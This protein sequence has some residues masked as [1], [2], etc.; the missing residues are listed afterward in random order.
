MKW[1]EQWQQNNRERFPKTAKFFD[2]FSEVNQE[3]RAD[4][5]N[6]AI[7]G[8]SFAAAENILLRESLRRYPFAM[9]FSGMLAG[10]YAAGKHAYSGLSELAKP[11]TQIYDYSLLAYTQP[12]DE[13]EDIFYHSVA[14]A[15]KNNPNLNEI[16]HSATQLAQNVIAAI[17]NK[18]SFSKQTI[19]ALENA[20]TTLPAKSFIAS[21]NQE[22]DQK[23]ILDP[24]ERERYVKAAN[25]Y[26]ENQLS[27]PSCNN[28]E[29]SKKQKERLELVAKA[30]GNALGLKDVLDN[31]HV[32][33]HMRPGTIS[34]REHNQTPAFDLNFLNSM[35]AISVLG[36]A[37]NNPTLQKIGVVGQA[38]YQIMSE[39]KKVGGLIANGSFSVGTL[40]NSIS[41]I[42]MAGSIVM[43][44]FGRK[45]NDNFT[46]VIMK[47]LKELSQQMVNFRNEV[48]QGLAEIYH[49]QK[50]IYDA[51]YNG[52]NLI[53]YSL[54]S[55][56]ANLKYLVISRL[57]DIQGH[58]KYLEEL[59]DGNFQQLTRGP[60]LRTISLIEGEHDRYIKDNTVKISPE[61]FTEAMNEL[62]FW[63]VDRINISAHCRNSHLTGVAALPKKDMRLQLNDYIR[64]IK[65]L[66]G[67]ASLGQA[68]GFLLPYAQCYLLNDKKQIELLDAFKNP[69]NM[70]IWIFTVDAYKKL[71]VLGAHAKIAYDTDNSELQ[72]ILDNAN[73]MLD[74]FKTI[75]QVGASL[76]TTLAEQY[77]QVIDRL[78][79]QLKEQAALKVERMLKEF[80]PSRPLSLPGVNINVQGASFNF[81]ANVAIA[82]DLFLALQLDLAKITF[83]GAMP[84]RIA[85][86]HPFAPS[87]NAFGPF[88]GIQ[89]K[90]DAYFETKSIPNKKI[91]LATANKTI[92]L[93]LH[94]VN[95]ERNK[96]QAE[97]F[98]RVGI[99]GPDN[100]YAA[101][102]VFFQ[103]MWTKD[104][105][106]SFT[107]IVTP[108]N[109]PTI[110]T[111]LE[112]CILKTELMALLATDSVQECFTQLNFLHTLAHAYAQL[113]GNEKFFLQLSS[114]KPAD[115]LQIILASEIASLLPDA[116]MVLDKLFSPFQIIM[117]CATEYSIEDAI[118]S[119][120]AYPILEQISEL[121]SLFVMNV[122]SLP[123]IQNNSSFSIK[124]TPAILESSSS[125]AASMA[126]AS[127]AYGIFKC[128]FRNPET[129]KADATAGHQQYAKDLYK[130]ILF[131]YAGSLSAYEEKTAKKRLIKLKDPETSFKI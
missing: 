89:Y 54:Q 107:P 66:N 120:L 93:T 15:P 53:Y 117:D 2:V 60:L 69:M 64:I 113:I 124:A 23:K 12:N 47:Q 17:N 58:L 86:I 96:L 34:I 73:S 13:I 95:A 97:G 118:R 76:F 46:Q 119:P 1:F 42:G 21:I 56:M 84:Q 63:L 6:N 80:G 27:L 111:S 18:Q 106:L 32:A 75:Q 129:R 103:T 82:P 91:H 20:I 79:L 59:I 78:K 74:M 26:L 127:S 102:I 125:V 36:T 72:S 116:D 101:P 77:N 3:V 10:G 19:H 83:E 35:Q 52:F 57:E 88:G 122:E 94:H 61:S 81:N 30:A 28:R 68:L 130:E 65:L 41:V 44:L 85:P 126:T 131:N 114:F 29:L 110:Q 38:S 128:A 50:L 11:N 87:V 33:V 7:E 70:D 90:F 16:G 39:L 51:I 104:P 71:R 40:M 123:A 99:L 5:I 24:K 49:T 121:S 108:P 109:N 43:K 37:F 45:K 9:V 48:M 22:L 105:T 25:H 98:R 92:A 62:T 14:N 112:N 115:E 100:I 31:G 67:A 4:I 8:A 55:E